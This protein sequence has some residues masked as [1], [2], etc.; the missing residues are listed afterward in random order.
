MALKV[1]AALNFKQNS[2]NETRDVPYRN[3]F[4]FHHSDNFHLLNTHMAALMRAKRARKEQLERSRVVTIRR[5]S[6]SHNVRRVDSFPNRIPLDTVCISCF[7][8]PT[9]PPSLSLSLSVTLANGSFNVLPHISAWR[10]RSARFERSR[11]SF[12]A[13]TINSG[14][15]EIDAAA[16]AREHAKFDSG[17][18]SRYDVTR[19]VRRVSSCRISK[20]PG[21][22][23]CV[24]LSA[25]CF[26]RSANACRRAREFHARI[27]SFIDTR[28]SSSRR[29]DSNPINPA[30]CRPSG[31]R[32]PR[33]LSSRFNPRN[34]NSRIRSANPRGLYF[35]PEGRGALS[36]PPPLTPLRSIFRIARPREE[37]RTLSRSTRESR[38]INGDNARCAISAHLHERC[39]ISRADLSSVH[40][41]ALSSVHSTVKLVRNDRNSKLLAHRVAGTFD[42]REYCATFQNDAAPR[43]S[44]R[45]MQLT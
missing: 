27:R 13:Q 42:K 37:T 11:C 8:S 32:T 15:K 35:R 34:C 12:P 22:K 30:L 1:Q 28:G 7:L 14:W 43:R 9:S 29:R 20:T 17:L 25:C 40:D 19:L 6:S 31:F 38:S 36:S 21:R 33:N 45:G 39:S 3:G 26:K 5:H 2:R 24:A 41:E 23:L 10:V 16:Q 18:R 4:R 44:R